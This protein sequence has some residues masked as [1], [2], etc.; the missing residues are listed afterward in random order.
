MHEKILSLSKLVSR[1]SSD[2]IIL[3]C[4][5]YQILFKLSCKLEWNAISYLYWQHAENVY[6]RKPAFLNVHNLTEVQIPLHSIVHVL[7]VYNTRFVLYE[8]QIVGQH[9]CQQ[10]T[11]GLTQCVVETVSI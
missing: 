11:E 1:Q 9:V 8:F 3:S 7:N 5:D 10:C 6:V 2:N 4:I